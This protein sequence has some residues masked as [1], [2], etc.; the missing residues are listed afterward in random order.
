MVIGTFFSNCCGKVKK[1][2]K[3]S[4]LVCARSASVRDRGSMVGRREKDSLVSFRMG[5]G[6]G[7]VGEDSFSKCRSHGHIR[8]RTFRVIF[9]RDFLYE[10]SVT[11]D[12]YRGVCE[13][14]EG[15]RRIVV[16]TKL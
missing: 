2:I 10:E 14:K 7:G 16:I 15:D 4:S 3:R 9:E 8:R 12:N 11:Q 13:K 6:G 1:L 5:G